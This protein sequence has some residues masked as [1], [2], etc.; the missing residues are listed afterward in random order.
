MQ[1]QYRTDKILTMRIFFTYLLVQFLA[2]TVTGQE[3]TV[4]DERKGRL[5][6]FKFTDDSRKEGERLYT[7][8]C[9]SCHGTPGKGDYLTTLAPLPGDPTTEKY[10]KNLDG[11]MF[12]KITTGR[13]AMPSFRDALSSND[14][15]NVIAFLRSFKKDYIQAIAPIIRSAAY[16][17]AD[18]IIA[19]LSVPENNTVMMKVTAKS[20]VT[21][22][23]VT[24]A[25]VK[26]YAKRTF[27]QMMVDE[28][29]STDSNGVALFTLPAGY[30]ADTAGMLHVSARFSDEETFGA[31]SKD[32]IINAGV[33]ITPVSLTAERAMWNVVRKAPVWVIL[34]Y[35]LGVVGVWGFIFLI[36][37]RLRD[38]F[39][40]GRHI[41]KSASVK[42]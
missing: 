28:E 42:E 29:K 16:P 19:L 36:M 23:P 13:G 21:T 18:I 27:G 3:W 32:T 11:E 26:L 14:I 9:K 2:V 31:V 12:Y 1:K 17:G 6:P 41:E 37:L 39:L 5:S 20:A 7:I 10:Q 34:S 38:I 40:I 8:N 24:G 35:T 30:P 25:G 4:P 15:W 33:K 22:V